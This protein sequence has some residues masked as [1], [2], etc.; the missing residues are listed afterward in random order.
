MSLEQI[1]DNSRTDKNTTHSYLPLYQNLLIRKKE[2]AKN[3]LEIGIWL[4]GS[5]KLWSDFFLNA[6]V[7][8]LDI[9]N[10]E[11]IWEGIKNKEKIILHTSID[12]YNNDFFITHFL[13]KNIKFDF[14]LDD[15]PHTLESMKQFI[16]LYSQI[17]TDD[18]ILIIEDVESWDWI[19]TL[20]N[21]VPEN[22]KQFIKIYDLRSIK[23]RYDDIV[24]TI[25]KLNI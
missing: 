15:G 8:G 6:N 18:G 10:I 20:K 23:N 7:Y 17:M 16:K 12:A 19:D 13:N 4:G 14:V 9:M 11:N 2:S 1:A 25:D 21:E 3:V 22:L 24:F 5:I